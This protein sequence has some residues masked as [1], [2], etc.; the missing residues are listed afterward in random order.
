MYY[1]SRL[2]AARA[3]ASRPVDY[4]LSL[5]A[6]RLRRNR[7]LLRQMHRGIERLRARG[8]SAADYELFYRTQCD[9]HRRHWVRAARMYAQLMMARPALPPSRNN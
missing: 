4:E 2:D 1:P 7:A 3:L 6:T 5:A 9:R 8:V